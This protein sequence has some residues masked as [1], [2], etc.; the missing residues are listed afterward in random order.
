VL[1]VHVDTAPPQVCLTATQLQC[2]AAYATWPQGVPG[3]SKAVKH[4]LPAADNASP[5]HHGKGESV[6]LRTTNYNFEPIV[7]LSSTLHNNNVLI[8]YNIEVPKEDDNTMCVSP[9]TSHAHG[10]D[11]CH[12]ADVSALLLHIY[13][14]YLCTTVKKFNC[15][16][17]VHVEDI[18]LCVTCKGKVLCHNYWLLDSGALQHYT[19]NIDNCV[20]YTLWTCDNYG[21]IR[22]ATTNTPVIGT[23]TVMIRVPGPKGSECTL[24]V[25]NVWHVPEIFTCLMSLGLFLQDNMDLGGTRTQS[26]S[27][28]KARPSCSTTHAMRATHSMA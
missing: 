14:K 23:G 10:T 16:S 9:S 20:D 13:D 28:K 21:Y 6:L 5:K 19:S 12:A 3:F 4:T 8:E 25:H 24:Q 27:A 18:V 22:T 15:V 7:G 11:A 2:Q 17:C 26:G 1:A